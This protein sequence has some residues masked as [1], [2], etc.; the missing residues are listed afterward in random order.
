LFVAPDDYGPMRIGSFLYDL[1]EAL[2]KRV[3]LICEEG[4]ETKPDMMED[5][6]RDRRLV[7]EA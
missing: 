6:L 1:Q 3:D 5:V 2:E 7:F 4:L